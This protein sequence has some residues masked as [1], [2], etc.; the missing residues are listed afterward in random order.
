[1]PGD[2]TSS[3]HSPTLHCSIKRSPAARTAF[4]EGRRSRAVTEPGGPER[5]SAVPKFDPQTR[6]AVV[7]IVDPYKLPAALSSVRGQ[8]VLVTGRVDGDVLRFNP[9]KGAESS[10]VL[11]DLTA[12]AEA[13]D[14][15]LVVLDQTAGRQPGGRNWLWQRVEVK[16]L[17]DALTRASFADFLNALG[18][19]RG[20][21]AVT[22]SAESPG[23]VLVQAT[24]S[25]TA[26]V[27]GGGLGGGLTDW[28]GGSRTTS[29]A[30]SWVTS[31]ATSSPLPFTP[32]W[33]ARRAKRNWTR[34]SCHSCRRGF[35]SVISRS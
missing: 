8:T 6:A 25:G 10:I 14:V 13:A 32:T 17:D 1:M 16:G 31:P 18:A 21:L 4:E 35:R 9:P 28:V 11:K 12:A 20:Q 24:P 19:S 30:K 5:L 34:A 29:P 23:R 27:P 22:A 26:A 7:D 3:S 15:N 33:R 2:P